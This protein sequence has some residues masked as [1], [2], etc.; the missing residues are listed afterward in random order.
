[1]RVFLILL[2]TASLSLP[3]LAQSSTGSVRG[4]VQDVTKGVLP[5]AQ[6]VLANTLTN[7]ALETLTNDEG[8]YVFP[9]V[10]PGPYRL[11]IDVPG[12]QKW[13]GTLTVQVQQSAVVDVVMKVGEQ[14]TE[15]TVNDVT[16]LLTVDNSALGH[17]LERQRIEQLPING[18]QVTN[19]LNTV[20]GLEG[21]RAYGMRTGNNEIVLDGAPLTDALYANAPQRQPSLEQEPAEPRAQE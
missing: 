10:R 8:I 13:E 20:P 2:M 14:V 17:V 4:T 6:V 5:G 9:S 11:V 1:M 12:M 18:R 7:V 3:V 16:P 21:L 19:L 15:V